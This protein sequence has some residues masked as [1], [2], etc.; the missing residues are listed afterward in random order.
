MSLSVKQTLIASIAMALTHPTFVLA[1][2]GLK[3]IHNVTYPEARKLLSTTSSQMYVAALCSTTT[4]R[5]QMDLSVPPKESFSKQSLLTSVVKK[6]T[7]QLQHPS[8]PYIHSI[9]PQNPHPLIPGIGISLDTYSSTS[10]CKM[11]I[12]SCPQSLESPSNSKDLPNQPRAGSMEVD[13]CSSNKHSKEKRHGCKQKDSPPSLP[14]H[15]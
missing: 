15:K 4:M 3:T 2:N 10:R 9:K 8:V 7:N 5:V 14:T 1:L 11:I 12:Y 6:L 13:R